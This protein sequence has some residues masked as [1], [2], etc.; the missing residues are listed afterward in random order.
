MTQVRVPLSTPISREGGN[1]ITELTLQK[2]MAGQLRGMK[3]GELLS[4]DVNSLM[5]LLPRIAQPS[6]TQDEMGALDPADLVTIGAE[7]MGFFDNPTVRGVL[8][9]KSLQALSK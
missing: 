5:T 3:L 8:Q 1:D 4:M 9:A 2:P 6:I 7:V